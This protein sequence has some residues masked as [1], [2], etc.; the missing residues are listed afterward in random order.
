MQVIHALHGVEDPRR[1]RRDPRNLCE[2]CEKVSVNSM[3]VGNEYHS[4]FKFVSS[5]GINN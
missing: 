3:G 4:H 5:E 1:V 2:T